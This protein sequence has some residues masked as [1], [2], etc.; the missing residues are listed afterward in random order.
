[1]STSTILVTGASSG[2]GKLTSLTLARRGHRVFAT[3]RDPGG[4]NRAS[5]DELRR[6][7]ELERVELNVL[8]LDVTSDASVEAA[9]A[10]ALAQAGRLDVAVNN[11][12]YGLGGLSETVTPAQFLAELD[13]NVVGMQR[14]NRA[15][16]PGMRANRSGLLVHVSSTLGR[17]VFPFVGPYAAT[18]WAVEALAE[19][20]RYELK[21]TGVES[22]IVQPGAFPTEFGA[23][24]QAGADPARA[25]GYGPL[26]HGFQQFG[27][28]FAKMF[29]VPNP[30]DP[31]EVA[32]AIADL[33]ETPA[34]K[35]PVRVVVDRFNGQGP[36]ALN[37]AHAGAQRG[38]LQGM[39]MELLAD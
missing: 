17:V 36:V 10:A 5:A 9:V 20:Y 26:E 3:M 31:Q 39:G 13:T 16:L 8:E 29:A 21:P 34:G 19:I 7:A 28:M 33:I 24:M 18:K 14:V 11:A 2:F 12:G 27:E 22:T 6:I 30:P 4:K 37:E 38:M 1:M 32:D 25:A 35:R 15:V 23:A